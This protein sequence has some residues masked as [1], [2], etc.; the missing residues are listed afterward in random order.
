MAA[1]RWLGLKEER[2][3]YDRCMEH[4]RKSR[5]AAELL[6]AAILDL[7]DARYDELEKIAGR[8]IDIS[9]ETDEMAQRMRR[10][11]GTSP[12][13]TT[14]RHDILTILF[15]LQRVTDGIEASAFRIE[16]AEGLVIPGNLV[17]LLK[18]LADAVI[19]TV[20]SL[21]EALEKVA[22]DASGAMEQ[23]EKVRQWESKVDDIRRKA[24]RNLV[25]IADQIGISTFWR[26]E[27]VIKHLEDAADS[28]EE[29]ANT[30]NL[31]ITSR[32]F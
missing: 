25:S 4:A 9:R 21:V 16:M 24:M 15:H 17:P 23:V 31:V 10:D 26:I 13:D 14:L 28:S 1:I 32:Q 6:K 20:R 30:I 11:I 5:E 3:L 22:Y 12:L 27:E 8:I 19:E 29:T 2:R 7:C 18:E